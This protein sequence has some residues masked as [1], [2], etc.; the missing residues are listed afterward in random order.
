MNVPQF[1]ADASLY[2]TERRYQSSTAV[3]APDYGSRVFPALVGRWSI[4]WTRCELSCIEVCTRFCHP[5]GWA[6]C[7]WE[8]RCAIN[9]D[10]RVIAPPTNHI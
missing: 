1:T 9:C 7:K 4:P 10:G 5:T 2:R 8:T 3:L 6:C